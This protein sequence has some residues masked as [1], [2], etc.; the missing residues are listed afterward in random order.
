MATGNQEM[1]CSMNTQYRPIS[2]CLCVCVCVCVFI[3]FWYFL[4]FIFIEIIGF[5]FGSVT[6]TVIFYVTLHDNM[7]VNR[8]FI[9]RVGQ[10]GRR[11][12]PLL[13]KD[14]PCISLYCLL[15][16]LVLIALTLH[17]YN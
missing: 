12:C 13:Q 7:P 4:K 11:Q 9:L 5:I 3:R 8:T 6:L 14:T 17:A 10:T 15:Y 1:E 16:Y 2:V